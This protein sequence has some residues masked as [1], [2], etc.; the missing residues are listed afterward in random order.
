[1]PLVERDGAPLRFG[2]ALIWACCWGAGGAAGAT[3]G[4]WLTAID[5]A[6]SSSGS[7]ADPARYLLPLWAFL[8]VTGVH[9]LMQM[10]VAYA[11]GARS[12]RRSA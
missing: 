5:A 2:R 3:L 12:D 6:S 8:G 11:R 1:M 9:L 10:A 4:A 7:L